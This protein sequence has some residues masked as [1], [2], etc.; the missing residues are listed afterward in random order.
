MILLQFK[1]DVFIPGLR[2][3]RYGLVG[4]TRKSAHPYTMEGNLFNN[5]QKFAMGVESLKLSES[6]ENYNPQD[7][8]KLAANYPFNSGVA[9]SIILVSCSTCQDVKMRDVEYD[10]KRKDI[11][12]H[13]L[14]NQEFTLNDEERSKMKILGN[15]P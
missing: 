2:E 11:T 5:A 12:L 15:Y 6:D 8:L 9:K 4:F 13:I 7:G 3:N 1:S 10:F 14:R